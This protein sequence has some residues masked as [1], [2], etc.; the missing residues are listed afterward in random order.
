MNASLLHSAP[1][2][3]APLLTIAVLLGLA[4]IWIVL[5]VLRRLRR[6]VLLDVARRRISTPAMRL[7]GRPGRRDALRARLILAARRRLEMSERDARRARIDAADRSRRPAGAAA[8][9]A[10]S[11]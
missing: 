8:R 10:F 4:G 7:S 5:D 11:L 9:R 1:G 2:A 3:A 6:A